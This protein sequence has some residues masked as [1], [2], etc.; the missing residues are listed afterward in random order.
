MEGTFASVLD[1]G[2]AIIVV[3]A[4]TQIA[5]VSMFAVAVLALTEVAGYLI[6]V[7]VQM[8][9]AHVGW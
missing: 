6:S 9:G 3:V 7:A 4:L 2:V 1:V 8:Q 5:S